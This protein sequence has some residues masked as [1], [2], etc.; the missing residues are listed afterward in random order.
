MV[1]AGNFDEF[2]EA[3]LVPG[4]VLVVPASGS[5]DG[6]V[7][8]EAA[9]AFAGLLSRTELL[10]LGSNDYRERCSELLDR[11]RLIE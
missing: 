7:L 6:D 3:Q 10:V 11:A 8:P 5:I 2:D 4:G 1:P 9:M